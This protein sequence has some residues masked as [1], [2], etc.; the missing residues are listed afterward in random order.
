MKK[1]IHIIGVDH[2]VQ[3]K[4]PVP[5]YIRDEFRSFIVRICGE[6]NIDVI[7]EEFSEEA[8]LEVYQAGSETALEAA[9]S[10]GIAHRYCDP[11]SKELA[12]LGIPY[13]GELIE[14][15][16]K[17]YNAPP[18]YLLDRGLREKITA[19]A[20]ERARSYWPIREEFWYNRLGDLLE[21]NILFICG[22][23][24]VDRFKSFLLDRGHGCEIIINFWKQE[25]FS[26]YGALGLA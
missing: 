13:F 1:M 11:G 18:S 5:E 16:K 22:H 25:L 10:L 2:L 8:L 21:M 15:A 20:A 6:K 17:K 23:E 12:E 7:A 19:Y 3:Y 4:G 14:E 9:R 24:H 26:D